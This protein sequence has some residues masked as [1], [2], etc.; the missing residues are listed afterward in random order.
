MCVWRTRRGPCVNGWR[1]AARVAAQG[2]DGLQQL[3]TVP[4]RNDAKLLQRLVRQARQDRFVYLILAEGCLIPPEAQAP[5]PDHD[6]HDG[7]PQSG[8]GAYHLPGKRGCPGWRWGSQA[9]QST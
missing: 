6:V 8:G 4:N 1:L 3:H 2:G 5:Q 7:A 9:S